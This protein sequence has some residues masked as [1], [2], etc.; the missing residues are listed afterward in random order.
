M[1]RSWVSV[2][3]CAY[4]TP[5]L[6][7]CHL[8]LEVRIN[9]SRHRGVRNGESRRWF[10]RASRRSHPV[11]DRHLQQPGGFEALVDQSRSN[12]DVLLKRN[13]TRNYPLVE[14]LA[15]VRREH[16]R[17]RSERVMR[18]R[19]AVASARAR[20]RMLAAWDGRE[21]MLRLGLEQSVRGG[22][23]IHELKL[24]RVSSTFSRA[25]PH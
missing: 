8:P 24:T 18:A 19:A 23:G 7:Y 13:T 16:R 6:Y 15:V 11:C 20:H 22:R 25:S 2:L 4:G 12:I 10:S 5:C 14:T 3:E 17:E 21:E 9:V 1:G